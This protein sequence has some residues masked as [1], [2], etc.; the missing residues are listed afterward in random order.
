MPPALIYS[1]QFAFKN[2]KYT[3]LPLA[4]G[5]ILFLAALRDSSYS[6]QA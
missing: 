3:A 4:V 5:S 6:D 2:P 1:F